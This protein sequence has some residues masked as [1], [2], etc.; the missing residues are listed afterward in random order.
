MTFLGKIAALTL[1]M[2]AAAFSLTYRL[3]PA[4][5]L[6]LIVYWLL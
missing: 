3:A 4:I 6:A 2:L 1:I 5:A